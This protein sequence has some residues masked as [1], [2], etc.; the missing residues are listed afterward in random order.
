[1]SMINGAAHRF[2]LAMLSLSKTLQAVSRNKLHQRYAVSILRNKMSRG[3]NDSRLCIFAAHN[4]TKRSV[5]WETKAGLIHFLLSYRWFCCFWF[6]F[7]VRYWWSEFK[8]DLTPVPNGDALLA[9]TPAWQATQ[10]PELDFALLPLS[11]IDTWMIRRSWEISHRIIV[12]SKFYLNFIKQSR[13]CE[14]NTFIKPGWGFY[15]VT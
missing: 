8:G 1:M 9:M 11:I 7:W 13:G 3:R 2:V 15:A 4:N 6:Q 14:F 10:S 12:L 5:L